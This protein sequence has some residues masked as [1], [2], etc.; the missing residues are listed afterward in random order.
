[1]IYK[2]GDE[3]QKTF[4]LQRPDINVAKLQNSE[5]R[6]YVSPPS[7]GGIPTSDSVDSGFPASGANS[8]EG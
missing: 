8:D 2:Q 3:L 6:H 7:S 5:N 1:M 4:L